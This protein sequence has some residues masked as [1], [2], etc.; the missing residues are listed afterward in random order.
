[1]T[2]DRV[3]AVMFKSAEGQ[4]FARKARRIS[5]IILNELKLLSEVGLE[6]HGQQSDIFLRLLA[7]AGLFA[8]KERSP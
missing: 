6:T 3:D 1:L 7:D 8:D 5:P 4:I 2:S